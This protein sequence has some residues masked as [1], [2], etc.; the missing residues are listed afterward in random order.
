MK[1]LLPTTAILPVTLGSIALLSACSAGQTQ[2]ASRKTL[3]AS[4]TATLTDTAGDNTMAI[5]AGSLKNTTISIPGGSLA[6]GTSLEVKRGTEPSDFAIDDSTAASSPLIIKASHGSGQLSE[7][8]EAMKIAI[9][10]TSTS[11]ALAA[12]EHSNLAVLLKDVDD[13]LFIWPRAKIAVIENK[14]IFESKRFGVY[15]LRFLPN[16]ENTDFAATEEQAP[17]EKTQEPAVNT[18]E[19]SGSTD[20]QP[21][22]LVGDPAKYAELVPLMAAGCA[23]SSCHGGSNTTKAFLTKQAAFE[24]IK[25][26]LAGEMFVKK[27]MRPKPGDTYGT[28][29]PFSTSGLANTRD[30]TQAELLLFATFLQSLGVQMPAPPQSPSGY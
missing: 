2:Q 16:A 15:Q 29:T 1:Y 19:G 17:A 21:V 10:V 30:L 14:A 18:P 4:I 23:D 22:P 28:G 3:K 6:V 26:K 13:N 20:P 25:D 7:A 27:R 5:E 8:Q 11:L 12:S 24:K 9:P